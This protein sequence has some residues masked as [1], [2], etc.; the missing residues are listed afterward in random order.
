MKK[1]KLNRLEKAKLKVN[2]RYWRNK[3]DAEW[4]ISVRHSAVCIVC[5]RTDKLQAHHLISRWVLPLRHNLNNGVA[6]CPT[7][8]KWDRKISGH[9]GPMGLAWLLQR[10]RPEQWAWLMGVYDRWD[11]IAKEPVDFQQAFMRL[12][13]KL[14]SNV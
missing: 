2:S 1:K 11:E 7:C 10:Q 14:T 13:Y 6:M 8:H 3:A 4:S 12:N 5:G 9:Q